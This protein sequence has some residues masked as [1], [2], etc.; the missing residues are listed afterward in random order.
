MTDKRKAKKH[1]VMKKKRGKYKQ[2]FERG[3]SF[4]KIYKNDDSSD[5]S[6]L[7]DEKVIFNVLI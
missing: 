2:Y 4:A 7:D 5:C 3:T 6:S 1:T